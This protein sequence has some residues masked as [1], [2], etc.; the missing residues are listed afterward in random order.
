[1]F[2][3]EP[4]IDYMATTAPVTFGAGPVELGEVALELAE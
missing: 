3:P 2:N 4:G 1:M